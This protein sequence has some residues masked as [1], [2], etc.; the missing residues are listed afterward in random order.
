M[1]FFYRP[2][3]IGKFPLFVD[4]LSKSTFYAKK[5]YRRTCIITSLY[6]VPPVSRRGIVKGID[7]I[8]QRQTFRALIKLVNRTAS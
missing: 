8:N 1:A 5:L 7:V 6:T 3:K 2:Q 4:A